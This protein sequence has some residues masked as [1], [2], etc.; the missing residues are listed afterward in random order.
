MDLLWDT[1]IG[2]WSKK[3]TDSNHQRLVGGHHGADPHCNVPPP[4]PPRPI[5]PTPTQIRAKAK[6]SA[7][8]RSQNTG[9]SG[10]KINLLQPSSPLQDQHAATVYMCECSRAVMHICVDLCER[11]ERKS[12]CLGVG[13]ALLTP[14]SESFQFDLFFYTKINNPRHSSQSV[15]CS[16]K[17]AESIW[18]PD[19]KHLRWWRFQMLTLLQ[20]YN[21]FFFFYLS[22]PQNWDWCNAL[23]IIVC[24][25]PPPPFLPQGMYIKSTYDGL[26]VITGT[27]EGVSALPFVLLFV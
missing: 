7:L 23:C 1:E 15:M 6:A 4:T 25:I 3:K 12:V 5:H 19:D 26:H 17:K 13:R 16:K 14:F 11:T 20:N 18:D 9:P 2:L 22:L 8:I 21:F 24:F 27:T 10:L